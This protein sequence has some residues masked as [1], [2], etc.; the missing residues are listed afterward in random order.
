MSFRVG[1]IVKSKEDFGVDIFKVQGVTE[2]LDMI[3]DGWLIKSPGDYINPAFY[4]YYKGAL[5]A[6]KNL[7]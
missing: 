6:I 3:P 5:S 1:D 4:D 7:I 2:G